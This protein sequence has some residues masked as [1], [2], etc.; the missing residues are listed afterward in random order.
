[1]LLEA[2]TPAFVVDPFSR[3]LQASVAVDHRSCPTNRPQ[4]A[5]AAASIPAAGLIS[6]VEPRPWL[7][8]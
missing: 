6:R 3:Q 2:V 1:M 5:A 7:A 4:P 8:P